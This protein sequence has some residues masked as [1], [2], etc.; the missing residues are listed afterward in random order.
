MPRKIEKKERGVFEKV[1]NSDIWWIRY[2]DAEGR[3]HREKVGP[4]RRCPQAL[5]TPKD[6][7]ASRREA[8]S[9]YETQGTSV[10]RSLP[11]TPLT[12]TSSTDGK[13]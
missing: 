3:E 10:L 8:P 13:T 7:R 5:Q 1:P 2:H 11:R 6:G 9:K 12:G 4:S